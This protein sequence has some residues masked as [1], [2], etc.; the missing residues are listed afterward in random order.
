L[1]NSFSRPDNV[2]LQRSIV[3]P[4]LA[5]TH[6][7]AGLVVHLAAL[8]FW[9]AQV[10]ASPITIERF[11]RAQAAGP[12]AGVVAK[13]DLSDPRAQV[14]L[15]LAKKKSEPNCSAQLETPSTAAREQ[16][17]DIAVNASF[18]AAPVE[19]NVDGKKVRYFVGNCATPVGW[20]VNAKEKISEP[21]NDRLRATLI[22]REDGRASIVADVKTLPAKTRWAVSGNAVVVTNGRVVSTDA[23]GA[24]HPRTVAGLSEDGKTLFLVVVDG[25]APMHSVGANMLELGE[26]LVSLGVHDAVNLDGGGSTAMVVRDSAT[27]VHAVANRPSEVVTGQPTIPAERAVVDIIG[28]RLVSSLKETK[29]TTTAT[30]SAPAVK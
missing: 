20:H 18:F 5:R 1:R 21:A 29:P 3:P 7:C 10:S 17:F 26:L 13:I 25:R 12:L 28:V 24:R 30:P 14:E 22:M 2:M 23:T 4:Y 9:G 15:A 19:R 27:G 8:L 16:N 11:A 6:W